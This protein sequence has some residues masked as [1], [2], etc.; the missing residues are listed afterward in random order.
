MRVIA[1]FTGRRRLR[2]SIGFR[3]AHVAAA[4][5][6]SARGRFR[7]AGEAL[8][9]GRL[10]RRHEFPV[11]TADAITVVVDRG[12]DFHAAIDLAA[13]QDDC[14]RSLGIAHLAQRLTHVGST[15]VLHLHAATPASEIVIA[16][17]IRS[18]SNFWQLIVRPP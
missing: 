5:A 14:I 8:R 12:D 7:F 13:R 17:F 16:T 4:E 6:E 9:S 1:L 10:R 3:A 2:T 11:V 18:V 15:I